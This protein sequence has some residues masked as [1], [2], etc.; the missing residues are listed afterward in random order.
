M[1]KSC[2]KDEETNALVQWLDGWDDISV[3]DEQTRDG[4]HDS[5]RAGN[6]RR[7]C[8][9]SWYIHSLTRVVIAAMNY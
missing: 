5:I 1:N 7:V 6:V 9:P 3:S 2:M 8:L 4:F